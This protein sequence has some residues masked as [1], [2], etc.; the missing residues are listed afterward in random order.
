MNKTLLTEY[1]QYI[2]ENMHLDSNKMNILKDEF[3]EHKK[4]N[5][6]HYKHPRPR[7]R[8]RKNMIWDGNN[9]IWIDEGSTIEYSSDMDKY[10]SKKYSELKKIAITMGINQKDLDNIDDESDPKIHLV[11]LLNEQEH[12]E[13]KSTVVE[14]KEETL[15]DN[16][17]IF[18]G[19][20]YYFVS[21][22]DEIFNIEGGFELMGKWR[23]NKIIFEEDMEE[24]HNSKK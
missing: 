4:N 5:K 13:D 19:V 9:G 7:G 22:T 24:L 2:V 3:I 8:G 15:D 11:R 17:V 12:K 10:S 18:E 20:K 6:Q 21:D 16:K 1:T 23:D 14:K